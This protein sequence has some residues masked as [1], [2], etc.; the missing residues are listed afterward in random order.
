MRLSDIA[1]D[2]LKSTRP[3]IVSLGNVLSSSEPLREMRG[4][5]QKRIREIVDELGPQVFPDFEEIRELNKPREPPSAASS[6]STN[7]NRSA[8]DKLG[9]GQNIESI[10]AYEN[11]TFEDVDLFSR[12]AYNEQFGKA[13]D[14]VEF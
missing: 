6:P 1:I 3:L 7:F 14:K 13:F 8:A 5:L 9:R 10:K 2:V 11:E 4:D 12:D